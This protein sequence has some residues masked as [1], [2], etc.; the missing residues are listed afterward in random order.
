[1]VAHHFG[2][3][4]PQS[5]MQ[6]IRSSDPPSCNSHGMMMRLFQLSAL[7]R[8]WRSGDIMPMP[9]RSNIQRNS[10]LAPAARSGSAT[11]SSSCRLPS[12]DFAVPH[13]KWPIIG[14]PWLAQTWAKKLVSLVSC[15]TL[16]A[17]STV[18]DSSCSYQSVF[19]E[20]V[21]KRQQ[22]QLETIADAELRD[23]HAVALGHGQPIR[24]S[25]VVLDCGLVAMD[26]LDAKADVAG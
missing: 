25:S 16:A 12:S 22:V 20:N 24:T 4:E 21:S 15:G 2:G 11:R 9:S 1:M 26:C 14:P 6:R 7:G 23:A 10:A 13:R 19:P 17:T 18:M 5:M 3:L 8:R